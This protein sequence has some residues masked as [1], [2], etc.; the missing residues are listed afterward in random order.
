MR[1]TIQ[2]GAVGL[3]RCERERAARPSSPTCRAQSG[4]HMHGVPFGPTVRH[5]LGP[6]LDQLGIEEEHAV[7]AQLHVLNGE[8][9]QL[10]RQMLMGAAPPRSD[11]PCA[12]C[13]HFKRIASTGSWL[14]P[15]G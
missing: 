14:D 4:Q 6:R 12:S 2:A 15:C 5:V 8:G 10:A 3:V 9:M 1:G 13:G 7:V 11:I